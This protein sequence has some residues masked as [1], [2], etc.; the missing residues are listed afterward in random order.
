MVVKKIK[1]MLKDP[2]VKEAITDKVMPAIKKEIQKRKS[3]K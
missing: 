3:N 2:K 1:K